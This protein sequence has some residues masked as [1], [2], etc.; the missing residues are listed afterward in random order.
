MLSV[1]LLL[2]VNTVCGTVWLVKFRKD[3]EDFLKT[4]Y[5]VQSIILLSI[6]IGIASFFVIV[7]FVVLGMLYV[8]QRRMWRR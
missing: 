4:K 6:P 7:F 2:L 5:Y 1:I 8:D 3:H